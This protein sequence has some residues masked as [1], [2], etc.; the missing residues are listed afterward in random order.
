MDMLPYELLGVIFSL[1]CT[2]GGRTACSLSL[3]S[4]CIRDVSSTSRFH[5]VALRSGSPSRMASF[6]A[7]FALE[8]ARSRAAMPLLRHLYIASPATSTYHWFARYVHPPD[9]WP[10]F[11]T[12]FV[13][14]ALALLALVA[15][16]LETLVLVQCPSQFLNPIGRSGFPNL[17][18]LTIMGGREMVA[19]LG[20]AT[21]IDTTE[22]LYPRLVRLNLVSP[23]VL[24]SH[25]SKHA[26][27]LTHLRLSGSYRQD[28][29]DEDIRSLLLRDLSNEGVPPVFP[30]LERCI[31]QVYDIPRSLQ[32]LRNPRSSRAL[33]R[34]SQMELT[35][36]QEHGHHGF[37]MPPMKTIQSVEDLERT[38]H[39]EWVGRI[40]GGAG[41]WAVDP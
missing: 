7:T 34:F 2:D 37:E 32:S 3:V 17:R 33:A 23:T 28:Y 31:V 38:T 21:A 11:G 8:R 26:P 30:D 27:H 29:I 10:Y 5:S 12:T 36:M 14:H 22:P 13:G 18:E 25:W 4:K 41:W 6:L 16:E 19:E 15:P 9:T 35:R 39:H 1:A 20:E 40:G 24:F